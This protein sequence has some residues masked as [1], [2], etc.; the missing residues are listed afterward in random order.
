MIVYGY[1]IVPIIGQK[2][3]LFPFELPGQFWY[4]EPIVHLAS[5]FRHLDN[6]GFKR[7][8]GCLRPSLNTAFLWLVHRP[9]SCR[10]KMNVRSPNS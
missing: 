2:Y 7:Q 4:M 1:S 10:V 8:K 9:L 3:Y 5:G 6:R